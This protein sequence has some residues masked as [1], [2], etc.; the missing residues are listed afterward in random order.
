MAKKS[1]QEDKEKRVKEFGGEALEKIKENDSKKSIKEIVIVDD[2]PNYIKSLKR[3]LMRKGY[4]VVAFESPEEFLRYNLE[5]TDL[6]LCDV[7][8]PMI[9]GFDVLKRIRSDKTNRHIP[10]IFISGSKIEY[11]QV[12]EAFD[13]GIS[14]FISKICSPG[15]LLGRV[16]KALN[17]GKLIAERKQAEEALQRTQK[18]LETIMDA[19]PASIFYKDKNNVILRVN[20]TYARTRGISKEDIEGISNFDIASNRE[21]VEAYWQDD[22]EVIESGVPKRNIVEP[23][24]TDETRWFQTDKLP[25][26]D[27]EGNTIGVIGFA[28]EITSRLQAEEA[29]KE[30]EKK[31]HNL[32]E[33]SSDAM[34]FFERETGQMLDLNEAGI[35]MYGYSR[36]E[37]LQIKTT[38]FSEEPDK[39]RQAITEAETFIPVRYHRKKDGT[40]FPT[41]ISIC[42][43]T[44]RGKEVCLASIRDITERKQSEEALRESEEKYRTLFYNANEAIY[45]TQDE[46][47]KF[48][49]PKME[50]LYGYSA[51][52]L[53]SKPFTCFIHEKDRD[54]VFERYKSRL[55][56]DSKIISHV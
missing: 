5:K 24:V 4:N 37:A 47:I 48:P 28:I 51:E 15:E 11:E 32:F 38:D 45:V 49:N 46:K 40:V 9:N 56:A 29:L 2:D 18:E 6:I 25:Y 3:Q 19:V 21:V 43:F 41:E 36:E 33:L 14:D 34:F 8:M 22:K 55:R 44:W 39:T 10:F 16:K 35:N 42:Y 26:R 17:E 50:E 54:M 27:D 12:F 13:S 30:N 31:Y 7:L 53:T 52:E 20:E 23:L 1:S